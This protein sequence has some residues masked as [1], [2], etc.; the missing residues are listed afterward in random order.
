MRHGAV[1]ASSYC[2]VHGALAVVVAT[3]I[4]QWSPT[5][6]LALL[7]VFGGVALIG[8]GA[9]LSIGALVL[10]ATALFGASCGAGGVIWMEA[11]SFLVGSAF[12][13]RFAEAVLA[14]LIGAAIAVHGRRRAAPHGPPSH[15]ARIRNRHA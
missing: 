9:A 11:D 10:L 1:L 7:P 4:Y 2:I 3:S 6:W 8:A 12:A 5:S 15:L 13:L 14:M